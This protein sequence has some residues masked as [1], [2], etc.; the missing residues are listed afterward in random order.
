MALFTGTERV[1]YAGDWVLYFKFTLKIIRYK[2]QTPIALSLQM[3]VHHRVDVLEKK[4]LQAGDSHS[5]IDTS[6]SRKGSCS[7]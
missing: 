5:T 1:T 7:L 6:Q 3:T 2:W 4:E